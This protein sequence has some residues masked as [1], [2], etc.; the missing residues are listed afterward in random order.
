MI[1]IQ[2]TGQM[3]QPNIKKTWPK[4]C[5]CEVARQSQYPRTYCSA[6]SGKEG[7]RLLCSWFLV[8]ALWENTHKSE[9]SLRHVAFKVTANLTKYSLVQNVCNVIANLSLTQF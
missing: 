5:R 8:S 4:F 1:S 7:T 3:R 2:Q 6:W 9:M